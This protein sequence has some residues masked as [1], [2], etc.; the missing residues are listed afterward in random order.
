MKI[1]DIQARNFLFSL[2][3]TAEKDH[4]DV[5]ANAASSLAVKLEVHRKEYILSDLEVRIIQY[6]VQ[7]SQG[8]VINS[9]KHQRKTY[10]RR[11]SLA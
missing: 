9:T 1:N 11:V 6:A 3:N 2:Y 10:K 8:T 5:I 4:N 7:K